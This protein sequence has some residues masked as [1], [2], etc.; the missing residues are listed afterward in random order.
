MF[1]SAV[2]RYGERPAISDGRTAWTYRELGDAIGRFVALYRELGIGPGR[3]VSIL[4]SNRVEVWAAMAA[5]LV[6]GARYTPLHPKAGP[7][8][9]A[10]VLEDAEIDTLIV[11]GERFAERGRA[12]RGR[13]GT[14][15][16]LLSFG[17]A[18]GLRDLLP[19][20]A[21]MTSAPL[22]D[23]GSPD[24][25]AWLAYT[26]GT[27][28]RSKGAMLPH[29]VLM[30]M[31]SLL[32]SDWD[33]PA[34][35]RFLA[36]T[37]ISH[38][39]GASLFPVV[40]RGGYVRL[41]P[42]FDLDAWCRTVEQERITAAFLVPTIVYVLLDAAPR[43][44]YDLRSLET[45][46]YGASPMSPDRLRQAL[47]TFGPIFV[48]MYGQTEAPQVITTLRKADHDPSRP[49]LLGSCGRPSPTVTVKLFDA[50]MREVPRGQPG[51]ICV[52]GPIVMDGYWKRPEATA[53]AFRGGWLHTGDVA[54]EDEAGFLHIVDRTK[55][56]IITGGFNVYPREVEDALMSHPAVAS[57]MV[58]GVPD[59][60]W[61]EA[62]K[63]F[64]VQRPG[65]T[66]E[67][68]EL[69][70]HVRQVR[71]PVWAPKSVEFRDSL[72]VTG[73]GKPDRKALRAPYWEG[74]ERGVA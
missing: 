43:E 5:A 35:I 40:L 8:D 1:L 29:R 3:G 67:A 69:Q 63:A 72:P 73:L 33:W 18:E 42:E 55:D 36:C 7:E 57:A 37:P 39:A 24:E 11:E 9:H 68:A 22:V 51:E 4:A 14:L 71:G 16:H 61:G 54:I 47:A 32:A 65:A 70:A 38:A 28:G 59:D 30:A 56:M 31:A 66:V 17:P 48:Q 6:I 15:R 44:K 49:T 45:L 21:R 10:F 60:K 74:R 34:E 46:V 52:R 27:T 53:E 50:E 58:I 64:V 23:A 13:V 25:I 26:G 12:I 41:L 62:V 2:A 19:D 20:L